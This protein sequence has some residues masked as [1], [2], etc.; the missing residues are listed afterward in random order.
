MTN[1]FSVQQ[2]E[3]SAEYKGWRSQDISGESSGSKVSMTVVPSNQG[4]VWSPEEAKLVAVKVRKNLQQLLMADLA[5]RGIAPPDREKLA[6]VEYDVII[7]S[8][9]RKPL[10][11][12][13]DTR[14]SC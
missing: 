8:L 12:Q 1:G 2:I 9:T 5:A 13:D 3:V 14:T 6:I 11:S 7:S 4:E 10:E